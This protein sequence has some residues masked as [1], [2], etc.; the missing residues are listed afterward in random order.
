MKLHGYWR[1]TAAYRTRIALNLK[2]IAF[3]QVSVDLRKGEQAATP[4]RR[5]NAQGLVPTLEAGGEALFQSPAIIEWLEERYPTPPLLPTD[6]AGR[7]IVRGMAAIIGCD[8][9]PLNNL[10]VLNELRDELHASKA[11]IDRWIC[12]WVTEGFEAIE[13]LV[14]RHG[15]GFAFGETPTIAD[16]YLVP[17]MYSARRFDVPVEAFPNILAAVARASALDSFARADPSIQPDAD[18]PPK[19]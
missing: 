5:L 9:H 6:A 16:V 14:G 18:T 11:Q 12:R 1:S 19:R 10:R 8:I 7:A 2:G 15:R 13:A 4:Y 17:Q 3:E